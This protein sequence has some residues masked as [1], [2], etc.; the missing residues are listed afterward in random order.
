MADHV[1]SPQT[2][3]PSTK[4]NNLCTMFKYHT[5]WKSALKQQDPSYFEVHPEEVRYKYVTSHLEC[6]DQMVTWMADHVTRWTDGRSCEQVDGWQI[7]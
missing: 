5:F 1:T 2:I 3:S 7:M 4:T 6:N